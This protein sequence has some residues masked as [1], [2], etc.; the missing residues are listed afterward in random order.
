MESCA[1]QLLM[2]IAL[3]LASLAGCVFFYFRA[4]KA[5]KT[6]KETID[7]LLHWNHA[8]RTPLTTIA[9]VSEILESSQ[10]MDEDQKKLV[11]SLKSATA[12]LKKIAND[13]ADSPVVNDA[14]DKK[15]N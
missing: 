8:L 14:R 2:P 10:N 11:G 5:E 4:K 15:Q 9:G 12:S 7:T 13:L 3:T 1:P 6:R